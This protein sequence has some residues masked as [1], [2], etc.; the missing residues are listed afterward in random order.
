M[1]L[2]YLS[3]LWGRGPI[4]VPDST[5]KSDSLRPTSPPRVQK[6]RTGVA[7]GG[8]FAALERLAWL[9]RKVRSQVTWVASPRGQPNDFT[10]VLSG[11]FW[12]RETV[13][14]LVA[15]GM[16]KSPGSDKAQKY[17]LP[18]WINSYRH[19]LLL[20]GFYD[21][22]TN[23]QSLKMLLK[24]Q[25]FTK[26]SMKLMKFNNPML[27]L[28]PEFFSQCYQTFWSSNKFFLIKWQLIS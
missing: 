27:K 20:H 11:T 28:G 21:K 12:M 3:F 25:M 22:T 5:W 17:L 9:I 14:K 4:Q 13:R 18:L 10:F 24:I 2:R 6:P 23:D 15:I 19:E 16:E 26:N 7:R 1:D 8:W